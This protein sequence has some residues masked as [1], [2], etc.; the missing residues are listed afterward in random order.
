MVTQIRNKFTV[1]AAIDLL[2]L[3]SAMTSFP[4]STTKQKFIIPAV[5]AVSAR[6]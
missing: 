1:L 3:K 2:T 5:A 6:C 4:L